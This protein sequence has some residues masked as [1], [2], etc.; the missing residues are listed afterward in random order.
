MEPDRRKLKTPVKQHDAEINIGYVLYGCI[1]S[2]VQLS[3]FKSS[4][5]EKTKPS[6]SIIKKRTLSCIRCRDTFIRLARGRRAQESILIV[7]S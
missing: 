5:A 2:K 6:P 1:F 7:L 3:P 4:I